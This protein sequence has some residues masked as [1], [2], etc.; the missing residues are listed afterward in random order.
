MKALRALVSEKGG[1]MLDSEIPDLCSCGA[2]RDN[3]TSVMKQKGADEAN[4]QVCA[5]NC[6]YYNNVKGYE[7]A[8]RDI[9]HCITFFR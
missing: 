9:L 1:K 4:I 6:Q 2:L 3:V 5:S 8:L 7:R